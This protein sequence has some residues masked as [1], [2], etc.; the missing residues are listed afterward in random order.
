MCTPDVHRF[1]VLQAVLQFLDQR[2]LAGAH[3]PHEVEDLPA[4]LAL[5]RRGMEVAH[6]LR[7]Y[8]LDAEELVG[9]EFVRLHRFVA[10]ETTDAGISVFVDAAHAA[11]HNAV[12]QPP[13]RQFGQG[14]GLL[15][16]FQV[17]EKGPPPTVVLPG[18][19]ILPNQLRKGRLISISHP[20]LLRRSACRS[21]RSPRCS[22]LNVYVIRRSPDRGYAP[23]ERTETRHARIDTALRKRGY[24][25]ET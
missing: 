7:R 15:D 24:A 10:E 8:L 20:P 12:V 14:R 3:R 17:V 11:L 6:D 18:L 25:E 4:L 5:Q 19:A 1:A 23:T 16:E 21:H 13:V 22:L 9:E 2:A